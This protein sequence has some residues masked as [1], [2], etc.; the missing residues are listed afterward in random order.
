MLNVFFLNLVTCAIS[1]IGMFVFYIWE[2]KELLKDRPK[3]N[4]CE[5]YASLYVFLSGIM[6]ISFITCLM[7]WCDGLI[8]ISTMSS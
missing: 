8:D 3:M 1:V 7:M 5:L 4:H 2:K 6:I